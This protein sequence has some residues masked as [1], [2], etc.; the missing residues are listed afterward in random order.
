MNLRGI[1]I[2]A[3]MLAAV[4][5]TDAEIGACTGDALNYCSAA[6][7]GGPSAVRACLDAHRKV[8]SKECAAV[9]ARHRSQGS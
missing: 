8:I 3:A 6:I 4:S 5:A 9:M 7:G 1:I 2:A